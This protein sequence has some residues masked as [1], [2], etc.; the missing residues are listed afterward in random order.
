M[1]IRRVAAAVIGAGQAGLA[2][3]H[4]LSARGIEHVVLERGRVA[5]RW[6]SERWESLRLL[7]PNWQTRLPGFA[8]SGPE[9]DGFMSTSQVVRFL[10]SY[11]R[12]SAAPVEER[13]AVTAVTAVDGQFEIATDRGI[14]RADAVTI[15]TGYCDRPR[16][17]EFAAGLPPSVTQIA[18][19][20]YRRSDRIPAG[21]V[22]VVGA[23]ASGVHLA[24]ELVR[25]GRR[26]VLSVGHHTRVP[27][28]YRG[29]DVMW[30]LDRMGILDAAEDDVYD[31]ELSRQQPS[32]QLIGDPDHRSI[33]LALLQ[34]QGVTL[35]GRAI[36]AA[37]ERVFFADDLVATTAAADAKLALLLRSI[38][39]FAETHG[40]QRALPPAPPFEPL[41]LRFRE[42][43]P[44][45]IDLH[46]AGITTV[47]WATGFG[48]RYDWLRIPGSVDERGEIVQQRGMTPT[49][50]LYVL[51]VQSMCR[52]NSSFIDGVGR[53][54][55][56][57]TA[58]LDGFLRGSAV[59][60]A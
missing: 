45:Q 6:R 23:A 50:G 8:Y 3:S 38:D 40:L 53:D 19:S 36:G 33:D 29:R 12:A 49:P 47:I 18:P 46:T 26:V 1:R 34:D 15:A 21:G 41:C 22:L 11:A 57:L 14:W 59:P 13:T 17:P 56:A 52:R 35:T 51:G 20:A 44:A 54:A 24:E 43:A 32:F 58:H 2:M 10:E 27:R 39:Q 60:A 5:E 48:R 42:P 16:V 4:C 31:V 25:S 7:T 28:T 30:W 37:G 55:H 9:P